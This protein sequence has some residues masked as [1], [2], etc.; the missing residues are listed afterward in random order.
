MTKVKMLTAS[1]GAEGTMSIGQVI[2]V[3]E[4]EAKELVEGGYA[5]YV[6][7]PKTKAENPS[8]ESDQLKH[9]GGGWFE[10]PNGEKVKGKEEALKELLQGS[11]E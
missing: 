4:K 7:S 10:L 9:V 11:D 3:D 6:D 5:Q 8:I 1:A 2:T